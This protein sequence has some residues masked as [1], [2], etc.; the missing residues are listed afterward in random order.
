M[1]LPIQAID[2]T[3]PNVFISD[4][5]AVTTSM[6]VADY[7]HKRHDNVIDKIRSVMADCDEKYRL[8]NFKETVYHRENPSGGKA[9]STPCF[10]LTRDAFVLIVMGFT[11]KKA[12]QWKINYINAFNALHDY[13]TK[14]EAKCEDRLP[15]T[16]VVPVGFCGRIVIAYDD[17]KIRLQQFLR[18][19][20]CI[21]SV[22]DFIEMA[23]RDGW[24]VL[25]KSDML[26]LFA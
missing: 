20:E 19:E 4:D 26:K 12:L 18:P 3:N 15:G 10:E 17:G 2:T 7:F 5:K 21:A 11:G 23:K 9:I 22:P 13:F 14:G 6:A 24:L 8:L 1:T 16:S 25:N